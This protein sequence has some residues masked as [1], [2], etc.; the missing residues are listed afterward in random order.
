MEL[1]TLGFDM[2]IKSKPKEFGMIRNGNAD[3]FNLNSG[4]NLDG[5]IQIGIDFAENKYK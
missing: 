1:P 4:M 5:F 3:V 2:F